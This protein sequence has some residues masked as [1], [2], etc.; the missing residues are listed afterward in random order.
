MNDGRPVP[1]VID[2]GIA[3]ALNQQLTEKTLFTRYGQMVGTPAYM[4]PEQA[5][6][7]ELDVDTRSD[8]YSLGVLLYEL[9]TGV[10]PFEAD[11]LRSAG[12]KEMQRIIMEE[13]PPRPSKRLSTMGQA[14]SGI[15]RHRGAQP[16]KLQQLLRGELDWIVMKALEKERN[17]RY[18]S[19][20]GLAADISRFIHNEPVEAGRPSRWYRLRKCYQRHRAAVMA[21]AGVAVALVIATAISTT[22]AFQASSARDQLATAHQA[23][24][25]RIKDQALAFAMGGN[26]KAALAESK[27]AR[28]LGASDSWC[29]LIDG[30]SS[31]FSGNAEEAIEVLEL[32][33][34]KNPNSV[35]MRGA[36]AT[37]YLWVGRE[38][39]CSIENTAMRSIPFSSDD[40]EA[41]LFLAYSKAL[42]AAPDDLTEHLNRYFQLRGNSL[43]GRIVRASVLVVADRTNDPDYLTQAER[44]LIVA[45]ELSDTN[46]ATLTIRMRL[47]HVGYRIYSLLGDQTQT[48]Y[49]RRLAEETIK[50]IQNSN[51][52][53]S[54]KEAASF[55]H[56]HLH[57]VHLARAYWKNALRL[58]DSGYCIGYTRF[59][60]K[61][62]GPE[63]TLSVLSET[64]SED[65]GRAI[66]GLDRPTQREASL[67]MLEAISQDLET[68]ASLRNVAIALLL[69]SGDEDA[70]RAGREILGDREVIWATVDN[71]EFPGDR[72]EQIRP[73]G[74]LLLGLHM[75]ALDQRENAL[76]SFT[77]GKSEMRTALT[78]WP[79]LCDIFATLMENNP[80]WPL[81]S[82]TSRG[83]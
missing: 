26:R 13:Q 81:P 49:H 10:T 63:A 37:A 24:L 7:S 56:L 20:G 82:D 19:P 4:S 23:L 34:R 17:A 41:H 9:L 39:E 5:E 40:A 69:A 6:M 73:L 51:D 77:V 72:L 75:T 27:H 36:L 3:K 42:V 67:Q 57:D 44:D 80:N 45:A 12:Y 50:E 25:D 46:I 16:E 43:A 22:F 83:S 15:S 55:L 11:R 60:L 54:H 31:I 47:H 76:R 58:C 30:V 62:D 32:A 61:T 35:A 21:V 48:E 2:F 68:H 18:E 28:Q 66:I 33:K 65:F 71:V 64:D 8:V 14:L 59:S 74:L 79:A 78:I 53:R 70:A 38:K 1:K 52:F 29:Q